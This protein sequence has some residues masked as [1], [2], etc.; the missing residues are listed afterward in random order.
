MLRSLD[1]RDMLIIERLSLAFQPGLV[2]A[3]LL[4]DAGVK[5]HLQQHI[6]EFVPKFVRDTGVHRVEQFVG[7]FRDAANR[8]VEAG[9]I[10]PRGQ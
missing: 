9:A 6:S 10:S 1:I 3:G 4:G 5:E 7:R 8:R 2:G